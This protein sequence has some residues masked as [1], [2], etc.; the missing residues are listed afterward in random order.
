MPEATLLQ[1][2][3][4]ALDRAVQHGA[5]RV[6]DALPWPPP[7]LAGPAEAALE[8][9]LEERRPDVE[10]A[11][12]LC[13][14]PDGAAELEV[15]AARLL[16]DLRAR[17][18]VRAASSVRLRASAAIDAWI[19][20][21]VPERMDDPS[22]D[23]RRRVS[24]LRALDRGHRLSGAYLRFADLLEPLLPA[25]EQATILD[26]ASGH[27]GFA[28]ALAA[29]FS[30]GGRARVIASDRRPEYL[31][32][33]LSRA[34]AAG[35]SNIEARTVDAF[36][37]AESLG[38]EPVDVVTCTM[39]LHHFPPGPVVWL[40]AQAQRSARR[41]FLMVDLVRGA[42]PLVAAATTTLLLGDRT[43]H[44]DGIASVRRAFTAEEL[45]LLGRLSPGGDRIEAIRLAADMVALR[46]RTERAC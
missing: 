11:R 6:I 29:R 32:L 16:A 19:R 23:E 42:R 21:D 1:R 14:Q 10:R 5:R 13:S 3:H 39:A 33:G 34:R 31:H 2:A 45:R 41:G 18:R 37:L 28:F 40:L 22:F 27:A 7:P 8:E 4:A 17:T 35:L 46:G 38:D 9:L 12:A 24:A 36:R 44:H 20:A 15:L 43:L 30:P 25:G 26:V